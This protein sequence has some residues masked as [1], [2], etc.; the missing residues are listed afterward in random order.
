MTEVLQSTLRKRSATLGDM[1]KHKMRCGDVL[2]Q[3]SGVG[4][5]RQACTITVMWCT[6]SGLAK[7]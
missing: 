3:D 7:V 6:G 1:E 5:R 2:L 4:S